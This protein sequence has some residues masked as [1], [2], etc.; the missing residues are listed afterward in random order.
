MRTEIQLTISGDVSELKG[1]REAVRAFL[2]STRR[3][4]LAEDAT[5]GLD[6][7]QQSRIILA[8]DEAVANIIEHGFPDAAAL[9]QAQIRLT[10]RKTLEHVEFEICDNGVAFNPLEHKSDTEFYYE[11]GLENG[12]G[13]ITLTTLDCSYRRIDDKH[14]I[15]TLRRNWGKAGGEKS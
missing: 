12:V 1:V 9:A 8:I 10:M 14:N 5:E 6:S 3:I 2:D 13:L 4:D 11:E 7:I 15:L